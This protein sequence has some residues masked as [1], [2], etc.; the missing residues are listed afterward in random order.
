[1][2]R[3]VYKGFRE[4]KQVRNETFFKFICGSIKQM[5]DVTDGRDLGYRFQMV[6]GFCLAVW[7]WEAADLLIHFSRFYPITTKMSCHMHG[8]Q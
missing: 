6:T 2:W 8:G 7:F 3:C 1:M 5:R 4:E